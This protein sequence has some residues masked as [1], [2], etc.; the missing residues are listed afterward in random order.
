MP[1][2]LPLPLLPVP[3]SHLEARAL[4]VGAGKLGG[5]AIELFLQA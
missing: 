3:L 2:T 1:W 4:S 5:S